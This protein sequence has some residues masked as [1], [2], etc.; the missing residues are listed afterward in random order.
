MTEIGNKIKTLEE[1]IAHLA[2][3]NEELSGE[4]ALQ[5]KRVERLENSLK[6]FEGRFAE[7]EDKKSEVMENEKPPHW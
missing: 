4:L 3:S 7:L 1:A 6:H 2:K 5:W